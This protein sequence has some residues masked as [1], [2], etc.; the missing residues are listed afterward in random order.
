MDVLTQHEISEANH[1]I[2]NPFTDEK[3]M[4]LGQVCRLEPG[5]R[6]LDLACGKGEMPCRWAQTFGI[7]GLG[8]DIS[9]VFL[10]AA[11]KRAEEL[12]VA[13]L[14]TFNRADAA[15]RDVADGAYDLVSCIGA[16]W[17]GQGPAGTVE[18]MR[19]RM[20][21]GGLML[22]GEP[23]WNEPPPAEAARTHHPIEEFASLVDTMEMFESVGMQ[24]VEMVLA[25]GDSWDRYVAAQWWTVNEWLQTN[26]DDADADVMRTKMEESRRWH[27]A[28][29]RRYLGWGVFVLRPSG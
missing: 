29:G 11:R 26:P 8:V 17:I 7:T 22:I 9:T 23:F 2:L 5:Q 27:L 19:P 18:L 6:Q 13:E 12:G 15:D 20:A 25:D 14:V 28:Y 10:G 1:R 21:E 3:L 4:L 16:T 24:L